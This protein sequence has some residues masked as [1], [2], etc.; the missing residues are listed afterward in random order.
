MLERAIF[1]SLL[2]FLR[3]F[4]FRRF[5]ASMFFFGALFLFCVFLDSRVFHFSCAKME[6]Q[7]DTDGADCF[8]LGTR[9]FFLRGGGVD[10]GWVGR[11]GRRLD[12]GREVAEGC[13]FLCEFD[14]YSIFYNRW[15]ERMGGVRGPPWPARIR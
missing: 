14:I 8:L 10:F 5:F 7:R 2:V 13:C 4:F 15:G 3:C 1:F 9:C 12:G 6:D 11:E